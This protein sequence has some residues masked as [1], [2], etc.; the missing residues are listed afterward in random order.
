MQHSTAKTETYM[1][2]EDE[3]E[4]ITDEEKVKRVVSKLYWHLKRPVTQLEVMQVTN[5]LRCNVNGRMNKLEE[6]GMVQKCG[7][8]TNPLTGR[9]LDTYMPAN[10]P[11]QKPKV[12]CPVCGSMVRI[13]VIKENVGF[14]KQAQ[15]HTKSVVC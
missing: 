9:P 12:P 7:T 14:T 8:R 11:P 6:K 13:E 10:N 15:H 2:R 5:L 3:G 1:C 4:N